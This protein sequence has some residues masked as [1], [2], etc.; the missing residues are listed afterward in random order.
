M[1]VVR[2]SYDNANVTIDLRL[3]SYDYRRINLRQA[4]ENVMINNKAVLG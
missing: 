1:T 3:R 2:L 4:L